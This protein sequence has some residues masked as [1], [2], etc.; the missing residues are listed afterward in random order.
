M[1]SS[2]IR[3]G[4]S[5]RFAP[6]NSSRS[7]NE[8]NVDSFQNMPRRTQA[9]ILAAD[10]SA[11]IGQ[12]ATRSR[13]RART[14]FLRTAAQVVQRIERRRQRRRERRGVTY[15][16]GDWNDQAFGPDPEHFLLT[17][18]KRHAGQHIRVV[19]FSGAPPED[20]DGHLSCGPPH[21]YEH[22]QGYKYATHSNAAN[23]LVDRAFQ[24]NMVDMSQRR[25]CD[26]DYNVPEGANNVINRYFSGKDGH[27]KKGEEWVF[28]YPV[29]QHDTVPVLCRA[30]S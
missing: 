1:V 13:T 11:F 27:T 19:A 2:A 26:H 18:F 12:L 25:I 20:D 29:L 8:K 15:R 21:Y 16:I 5:R 3:R 10:A 22:P 28:T 6:V 23:S 14:R 17:I 30:T 4:L 9:Q 24:T 7:T